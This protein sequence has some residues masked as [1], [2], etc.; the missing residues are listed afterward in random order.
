MIRPQPLENVA[1]DHLHVRPPVIQLGASG[2]AAPRSKRLPI[3]QAGCRALQSTFP[4]SYQLP[5]VVA[6]DD[7]SSQVAVSGE[8]QPVVD[9]LL[10]REGYTRVIRC[11]EPPELL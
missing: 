1:R 2:S 9:E 4:V 5:S 11:N 7:P 6:A 8:R 3:E 10:G